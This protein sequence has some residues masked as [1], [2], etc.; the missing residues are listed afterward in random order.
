MDP[1]I[2]ACFIFIRRVREQKR[3][4]PLQILTQQQAVLLVT[5]Q[6]SGLT[7]AGEQ[8]CKLS[9][10]PVKVKSKKSHKIV[11]S[12]ELLI[13]LNVPKAQ[14]PIKVIPSEDR[15]P[16]AVQTMLGWT[17]NGPLRTEG[18]DCE[19]LI[20]T[21]NRISAVRVDDLWKQQFQVDFPE[22]SQEEQLGPS[23][24]DCQFME[25]VQNTVKLEDGH[26]SIALLLRKRGVSMPNNH[27]LAE[28]RALSLK[29][30]FQKDALWLVERWLKRL[31]PVFTQF[32]SFFVDDCLASVASEF[33]AVALYHDLRAICAGGGFQLKKWVSNSWS[34]LAVIPEEEKAKDVKALDLD[35]DTLPVERAL[36]VQWCVESDAFRFKAAIQDRPLTSRGILS[37]VRSMTHLVY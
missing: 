26:Y 4:K 21:A 13:G 28:Q 27:K 18:G 14:K 33:K 35:Y 9:I 29:R 25:M 8:D 34:V 23:R 20:V 3:V 37:M 36:G 31:C 11:E 10:V 22:C 2:L 15:G 5:A 32:H 19:N 17:V 30:R 7:G 24:E 12:V 6:T 1:D 16:Y